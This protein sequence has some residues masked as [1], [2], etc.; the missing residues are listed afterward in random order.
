[1]VKEEKKLQRRVASV[2]TENEEL[3][4]MQD[5]VANGDYD[6]LEDI[7]NKGA[8]PSAIDTVGRCL[9]HLAASYKQPRIGVF[10]S[11]PPS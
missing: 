10:P 1:V 11:F 8:D 6:T 9:L 5:A 2:F 4:K 7:L 3:K